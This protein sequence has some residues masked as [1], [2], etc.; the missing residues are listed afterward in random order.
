M[1]VQLNGKKLHQ[2]RKRKAY[3]LAELAERCGTSE[4]YV[5]DLERGRKSNPSAA[6]LYRF[7]RALG[8]PMEEFMLE[9]APDEEETAFF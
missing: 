2:E 6:M 7:S 8:V 3:T 5:G 9:T 1:A 4:R